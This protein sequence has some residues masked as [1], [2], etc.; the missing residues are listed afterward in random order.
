MVLLKARQWIHPDGFV[1]DELKPLVSLLGTYMVNMT[2]DYGIAL[3]L[4]QYL[5]QLIR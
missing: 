3:Q 5:F 2:N 1:C 4:I